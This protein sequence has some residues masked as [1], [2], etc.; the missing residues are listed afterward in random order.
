MMNV[1]NLLYVTLGT[2]LVFVGLNCAPVEVPEAKPQAATEQKPVV[3]PGPPLQEFVSL[4]DELLKKRLE[5]IIRS[6]QARELRKDNGFW[7][8]FHGILGV[9]STATLTDPL[10]GFKWNAVDYIAG[11]G[12]LRG[13]RLIP[14]PFGV[15]VETGEQFV[16]QG[17]QDQFI[18]E[19]AECGLLAD[20]EFTVHG[21]KYTLRDFARN[22]Q[23]RARVDG[24]Q[25]LSW[26]IIVVG[27][28]LGTDL[29]WTNSY[30][31]K[32]R[33]EDLVRFEVN[34]NVEQ[35]ACGGTHRL[36]GL[37]WAYNLHLRNG[38]KTEGVWKDV[39]DEQ[40]R[41]QVRAKQMQNA[42]GS[43]STEFFRER[44]NDVG[45]KQLRM[46][47]TG[48]ILEWLAYSLP[49]SELRKP[50]V[51]D[52]VNS[53]ARMFLEIANDPM[54]SGSLYHAVHGLRL[55]HERVYGT[56]LEDLKP[57][58]ILPPRELARQDRKN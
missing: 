20:K 27:Q 25:E 15:D 45:N 8:I 4:D 41:Y 23:M 28:Y 51:V 30:G 6:V 5:S 55:Y 33:Y 40:V 54:E 35:A 9:G 10:L 16:S 37:Q 17:H 47:T 7:T 19:M 13:L 49:E 32:L 1:R 38:G 24:S 11:G 42:D 18:A 12:A 44:S 39:V 31:E 48:H 3:V 26:T 22:S 56:G 14:T 43:F 36:F 46:N 2:P 29:E 21:K 57:F 34:A 52:A 50:W 58:L 53:L